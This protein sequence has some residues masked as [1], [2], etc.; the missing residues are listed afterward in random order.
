MNNRLTF[1]I[2]LLHS[3]LL[4]I[5]TATAKSSSVNI[6]APNLSVNHH[7]VKAVEALLIARSGEKSNSQLTTET[8][9]TEISGLSLKDM[10]IPQKQRL[11]S[12][13]VWVINQN[14]QGQPQ[15]FIWLVKDLKKAG[16]P[17]LQVAN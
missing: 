2:I 14:K 4:G 7:T 3:L 16:Q 11:P 12:G 10:K 15:P 17:F 9:S 5:T 6:V 13:Q 8:S 1:Y